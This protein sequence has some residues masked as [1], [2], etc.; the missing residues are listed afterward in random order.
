MANLST[1]ANKKGR[2][3]KS[4]HRKLREEAYKTCIYV[5]HVSINIV[6]QCQGT[7]QANTVHT[8]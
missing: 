7:T 8:T 5:N 1:F 6:K 2:T 3:H 4:I